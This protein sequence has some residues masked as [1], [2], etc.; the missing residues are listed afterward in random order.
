MSLL[1]IEANSKQDVSNTF[2]INEWT[3]FCELH[4]FFCIFYFRQQK[5]CTEEKI[6]TN[7]VIN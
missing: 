3:L 4:T 6:E 7:A 1:Y 2:Y 5:K